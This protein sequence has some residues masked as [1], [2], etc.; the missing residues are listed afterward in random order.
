MPY[1]HEPQTAKLMTFRHW[2]HDFLMFAVWQKCWKTSTLRSLKFKFA[3]LQKGFEPNFV[4]Y[5]VAFSLSKKYFHQKKG[6]VWCTKMAVVSIHFRTPIGWCEV[7]WKCFKKEWFSTICMPKWTQ[8][9]L[10]NIFTAVNSWQVFWLI[11]KF[12]KNNT[13][14]TWSLYV[15]SDLKK[16]QVTLNLQVQFSLADKQ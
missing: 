4:L 1:K 6:L 16:I 12:N 11:L 14:Y 13:D 15:K 10:P 7:M 5:I 2:F 8:E 9:F 3:S